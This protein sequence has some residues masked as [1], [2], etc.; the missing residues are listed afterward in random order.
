MKGLLLISGG[1][2]SPVAGY[3]MLRKGMCLAA[4]HFSNEPFVT[5]AAE[6]RANQLVKTLEKLCGTKISFYVVQHGTAQRKILENCNRRF[7]CV[8]CKRFM[9]RV[10]EKVARKHG[11]DCLVTGEN[12]GQVASQT[13][14]NMA[15]INCAVTIPVLRP[16]LCNEKAETI[17]IARKIGTY[18]IS[19]ATGD[20]CTLAPN[21]PVTMATVEQVEKE[22]A[23]LDINAIVNELSECC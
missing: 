20:S 12:I 23:R 19:I 4:I 2:D 7:Q 11:Y 15:V 10:A 21:K 17:Q 3:L 5:D 16:L 18:D 22:E 8:L 9:Y 6:K 1:I 13:L 14:E